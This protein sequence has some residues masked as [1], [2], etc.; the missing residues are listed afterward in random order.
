VL[1]PEPLDFAGVT[2]PDALVI[3]SEDGLAKS[4][5]LLP[6]MSPEATVLAFPD[7][8]A[9]ETPAKLVVLDP[10]AATTR[11]PRADHGLAACA[12]ALLVLGLFPTD[13]L[14]EAAAAS[15]RLAEELAK[16]VAAGLEIG[17]AAH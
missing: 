9:V 7:V 13:A 1:S 4:R 10:A 14:V 5:A 6:R 2:V 15:G 11:L 3:L 16:V 12:A 17:A 8:A